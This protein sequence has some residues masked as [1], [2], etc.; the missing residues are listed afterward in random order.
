MKAF[1]ILVAVALFVAASA[2]FA[3][4]TGSISGKVTDANGGPLPGVM[5]KVTG[6]QLPAGRTFLTGATGAYNFQRLLPGSYTV[7]ASLQGLGKA[8]RVLAVQVDR[9]YQIDLVLKGGAEA[10]VEV[11]AASVDQRSTEVASN[12]ATEE[13]RQL[14]ITRSYEGLLSLIPGAPATSGSG[15]VAIAGGT[16]QENKY[17]VDGVN[18]TNPGYGYLGIDTNELDIADVAVKTGAISAEFGRT[19][20]AVVNAVTKSGTNNFHGNLR[21]EARPASFVSN[22]TNAISSDVDTYTG[23]AG[24]GFPIVKDTLFGYVSGRYSNTTTSG[25]SAVQKDGSRT[26]QPDTKQKNTDYFAKLTAYAGEKFL[27]AAGFRGLPYKTT[28]AFD[29]AYDA[30]TA[31]WNGDGTH[32]VGNLSVNWFA[33]K[34]TFAELKYV[35]STEDDS[36]GAANVLGSVPQNLDPTKLWQYGAFTDGLSTAT[37]YGNQGV[38]QFADGGEVYKRDEIKL[39]ANQFLELGTTQHQLKFGGGAEF[40]SHDLQRIS[41]GWGLIANNVNYAGSPAIRARFYGTQPQQLGRART[42]SIFLQDTITWKRISATIGVLANRDDF[43]QVCNAGVVC[44]SVASPEEI[45]YNFMTFGWSDQIQPRIGIVYA[46]DLMKGD[47]FYAN[48]GEYA[49]TDQ[50]STS[51]SFAPF[52]ARY[53]QAFFNRATGQY[54][55]TQVI[56]SSTG[57]VIPSDLLP[58]RQIEWIVGYAAPVSKDLSFDLTYQYKNLEHPFEDTPIDPNDYFGKFQ[59]K[60]FPNARRLYRGVTLDVTKRYADKWYANVSYTYS[61]LVGNWDEDQSAGVFNTSS[62]LEDEPGTNSSEPN[63]YGHLRQDRPHI[64]KVMASYDLYGF[65]VGTFFRL[66]SG[67]PWEARGNSPSGP[68]RYLEPAGSRRLPDLKTLDLLAAYTLGLG[69]DMSVRLE[70]RVQN[71]FN[72]QTALSVDTLQYFDSYKDGNPKSTLGP[73]G[74]TSPNPNF[75]KATSWASPRRFL[76]TA[77]LNF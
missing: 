5:V 48:Y 67:T 28:D 24:I 33:T 34:D 7:E 61:R 8:S 58:P 2:A 13:I 70:G 57:K 46:A 17:L 40:D 63:R 27:V 9:D 51:R 30:P 20:G 14:P 55:T 43:A 22:N 49:G 36:Y 35:H 60:N 3:G 56:G 19:S 42:Y 59:A 29:S 77:L 44:G 65:T 15:Y 69:G 6:P 4:E 39:V 21:F 37:R 10:V 25:Q 26:T 62:I 32:Y 53:D 68:N 45:R 66:Q 50:K 18:I 54:I 16:R 52:R 71:L 38:Y 1:R 12:F 64:L 72:D 23:S 74:T 47:K 11:T 75:G 76:L 73:Q 31:A 41:N